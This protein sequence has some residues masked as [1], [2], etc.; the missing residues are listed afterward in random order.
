MTQTKIA[1]QKI[2]T[3]LSLSTVVIGLILMTFMV[4]VESEPGAIPLFLILSGTI[5]YFIARIRTRSKSTR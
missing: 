2:N 5:W 3:L 1:S 4:T